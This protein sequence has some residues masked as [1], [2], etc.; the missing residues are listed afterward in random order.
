[1]ATTTADEQEAE[2]LGEMPGEL[3]S[4]ED[5]SGGGINKIKIAVLLI[6]LITV[7]MGIGYIFM[8]GTEDKLDTPDDSAAAIEPED[9][10]EGSFGEVEIGQ[11]NCTNSKAGIDVN[12]HIKFTL[13]A[14][15][16]EVNENT[17]KDAKEKYEARIR[18]AVNRVARSASHDDLSDPELGTIKRLLREEINKIL[19]KTYV[20]KVII[21]D[22]QTTER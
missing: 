1:M 5:D 17:F 22:W 19:R 4:P 2:A 15:V 11:F 18:D 14:E 21:P 8:P 9:D 12:I 16:R 10:S 20:A 13:Y 3:E 6:G 7:M